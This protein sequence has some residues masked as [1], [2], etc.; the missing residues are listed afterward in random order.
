MNRL[1]PKP[2]LF[3]LLLLALLTFSLP[4]MASGHGS[5]QP[6]KKG[7]VLVA[8]GT[9]VPEAAG[10]FK[11]VETKVR[12]A[13][14]DT[15]IRWGYTSRLIREKLKAQGREMD[16]PALALS[17]LYAEGV[18]HAAVLSLHTIPG[19]EF[20]DLTRTVDALAGL[21]D[22]LTAIH[23]SAPLLM[24]DEDLRR[25]AKLLAE[26]VPADRKKDDAV[27]WMGHGTP[28]PANVYYVAMGRYLE[29]IDP[30]FFVATVEGAPSFDEVL[31]ELKAR[32]VKKAF[33]APFMAVAGDHARND[34]A[35]P[36]ADS[37]A[38]QLTKAGITPVPVLKGTA[39]YDPLVQ[40]WVDHLKAAFDQLEH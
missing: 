3:P 15:P 19:E 11:N 22:G 28:H 32:K 9:S 33:L 38:S 21:P 4:A 17:R 24:A 10:A 12:A 13:F 31:A 20:S 37:W 25:V 5:D 39:E 18:T 1:L 36:E 35:G 8:F 6:A 34:M 7:I 30:L 2:L 16:T 40:I 27:V 23:L 14:P 26:S 29:R